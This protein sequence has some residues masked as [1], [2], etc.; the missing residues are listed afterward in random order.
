[1]ATTLKGWRGELLVLGYFLLFAVIAAHVGFWL[2]ANMLD[3]YWDHFDQ[4]AIWMQA[5]D[6]LSL[7][8]LRFLLFARALTMARFRL[9]LYLFSPMLWICGRTPIA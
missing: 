7:L 4:A 1:M 5:I 6:T 8:S 2:R 3:A 9:S